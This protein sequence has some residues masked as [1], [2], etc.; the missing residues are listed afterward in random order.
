MAT[1][2]EESKKRSRS[3]IYDQIPII[4]AKI[5][6]IGP[7]DPEIIYLRTIIKKRKER[8]KLMQAKYIVLPES[9]P[10]RLNNTIT[11]NLTTP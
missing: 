1:S 5:A 6:K 4:D 8:R 7:V 11:K 3:V 10:S 2:L 9:L